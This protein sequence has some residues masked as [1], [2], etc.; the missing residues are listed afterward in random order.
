[1]NRLLC[2]LGLHK[3]DPSERSWPVPNPGHIIYF[4]WATSRR[5]TNS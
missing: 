4:R 3:F 1:M 2:K 5:C